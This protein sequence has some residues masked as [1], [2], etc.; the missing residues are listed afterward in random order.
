[1][2]PKKTAENQQEVLLNKWIETGFSKEAVAANGTTLKVLQLILAGQVIPSTPPEIMTLPYQQ[3][4]VRAGQNLYYAT[5][6]VENMFNSHPGFAEKIIAHQSN[7]E[8]EKDFLARLA[9][10]EAARASLSDFLDI[11][12]ARPIDTELPL[13]LQ[14]QIVVKNSRWYAYMQTFTNEFR[15]Q[16]G[17]TDCSIDDII[18]ATKA[19]WPNKF[20]AFQK[21]CPF[22]RLTA[23][24]ELNPEQLK[25]DRVV[26]FLKNNPLIEPVWLDS[27]GVVL[28][29]NRQFLDAGT[30]ILGFEDESEIMLAT[31]QPVPISS[32]S[33]IEISKNDLLKLQKV[34]LA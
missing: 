30:P 3:P 12:K 5:P 24:Y 16:T 32:I 4:F 14:P 10:E 15:D 9:I 31:N 18:A 7:E 1:M 26:N 29:F 11:N 33:G 25:V 22:P 34:F 27:P 6:F 2:K 23:K 17:F 28:Y 20:R 19:L 13:E 21:R 8:E